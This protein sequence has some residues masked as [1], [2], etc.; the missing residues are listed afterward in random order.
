MVGI[1]STICRRVSLGRQLLL[2]IPAEVQW[3]GWNKF[4]SLS[5][6]KAFR[7]VWKSL[8]YVNIGNVVLTV[9]A[10]IIEATIK[11][12]WQ[13]ETSLWTG[14]KALEHRSSTVSKF[15]TAKL[16]FWAVLEQWTSHHQGQE[17]KLV[18]LA[19]TWPTLALLQAG[20]PIF[21]DVPIRNATLPT[22]VDLMPPFQFLST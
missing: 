16:I 22:F 3:A 10:S 18:H 8:L 19:M 6:N 4:W 9:K 14:W 2:N 7:T 17:V 5:W 12:C 20:Y 11:L 21:H 15:W 13:R 1:R